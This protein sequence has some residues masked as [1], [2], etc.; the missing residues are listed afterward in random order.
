MLIKVNNSPTYYDNELIYSTY[1]EKVHNLYAK[2]GY[3]LLLL[4]LEKSIILRNLWNVTPVQGKVYVFQPV[5]REN[6]M[7][8]TE[9]VKRIQ[10]LS[11][12]SSQGWQCIEWPPWGSAT[13]D[14]L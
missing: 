10:G 12:V 6:G 14:G 9:S 2:N 1:R 7:F 8:F 13:N 4:E 3:L 5:Q 11:S